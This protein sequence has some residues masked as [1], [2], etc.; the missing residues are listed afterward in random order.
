MAISTVYDMRAAA[1]K[2]ADLATALEALG[3]AVRALP[4]CIGV[5]LLRGDEDQAR[6]LMLEF[7]TS[8][9]AY[10]EAAKL[11]PKHLLGAVMAAIANPSGPFRSRV[12]INS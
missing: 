7:W 12:L 4:G 8:D 9:A 11:A 5:T 1:G 10:Q 2:E 6:F 3:N